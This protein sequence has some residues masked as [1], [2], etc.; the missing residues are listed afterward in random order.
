[1]RA[2]TKKFYITKLYHV[3]KMLGKNIHALSP[4]DKSA[5]LIKDKKLF[6]FLNILCNFV[7]GNRAG[8]KEIAS[9]MV[10]F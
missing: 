3:N 4:C 9:S 1:M 5:V 8:M 10:G 2:E 6:Y 7:I